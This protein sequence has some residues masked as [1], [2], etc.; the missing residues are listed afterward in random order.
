[1]LTLILILLSVLVA[2]GGLWWTIQIGR[3]QKTYTQDK[4]NAAVTRHTA[5]LN[6]IFIALIAFTVVIAIMIYIAYFVY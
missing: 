5:V 1:M 4:V 6:P 2:A 3:K